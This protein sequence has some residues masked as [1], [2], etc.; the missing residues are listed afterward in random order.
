MWSMLHCIYVFDKGEHRLYYSESL[1]K[2]PLECLSSVY[3]AKLTTE[4]LY[5]KAQNGV[6]IAVFLMCWVLG[7]L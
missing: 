3:E 5:S 7:A 6:D 2:L 1:V 4:V